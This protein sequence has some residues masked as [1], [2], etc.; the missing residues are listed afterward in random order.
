MLTQKSCLKNCFKKIKSC[1]ANINLLTTNCLCK[2]QIY[3][4]NVG[5]IS[6][7]TEISDSLNTEG[8]LVTMDIEKALV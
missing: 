5:L 7:I 3:W 6:D 8:F 4:K 2:K 1:F